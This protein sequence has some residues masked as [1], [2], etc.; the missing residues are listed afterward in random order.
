MILAFAC[1]VVFA[2]VA[3]AVRLNAF[4]TI[5]ATALGRSHEVIQILLFAVA[6]SAV[7]FWIEYVLGGAVLDVKPFYLVGV[8]LGG[9]LFGIGIAVLGYCPGT[10]PMALAEGRVDA[11]MGVLGGLRAG[12]CYTWIYPAILPFIGPDFG[13]INLYAASTAATGVVVMVYAVVLFAVAWALG[14]RA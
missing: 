14:R 1:G 9:T 8:V 10:L 4:D 13:A 5:I 6:I 12:A 7:G 11:L 2:L 3:Q